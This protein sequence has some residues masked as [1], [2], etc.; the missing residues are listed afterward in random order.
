MAEMDVTFHNLRVGRTAEGIILQ[1]VGVYQID[2]LVGFSLSAS[3]L[4]RDV[5]H[6]RK[7]KQA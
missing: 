1:F 5:L 2:T 4:S 3:A 7:G 6:Y